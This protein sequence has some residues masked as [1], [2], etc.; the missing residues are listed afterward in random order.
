MADPLATIDAVEAR[1]GREFA[2]SELVRAEALLVDVSAEIY[3]LVGD[4]AFHDENG[5]LLDP[6]PAAVVAVVCEAVIR[7]VENPRGLTGE[8][9]GDYNWQ[10]NSGRG[11]VG[12][13]LLA[14]ERRA[15]R[16]A[17]GKLSVAALQLQ[18]DLPVPGTFDMNTLTWS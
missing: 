2:G 9:I 10:A 5:D 1:L 16:R 6:V 3:G 11:S 14:A 15:V 4:D 8:T 18:G 13:Y 12:M 7:R 17:A